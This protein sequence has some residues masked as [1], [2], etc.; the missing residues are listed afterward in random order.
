MG[1]LG[2]RHVSMRAPGPW[3]PRSTSVDELL[4]PFGT[5]HGGVVTPWPTTCS[6]R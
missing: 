1:F 2:I 6:V 5:V 4:T 3:W